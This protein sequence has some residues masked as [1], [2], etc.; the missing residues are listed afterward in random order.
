MAKRL[1]IKKVMNG[2]VVSSGSY[3]ESIYPNLEEVID[4]VRRYFTMEERPKDYIKR[5][6]PG[7]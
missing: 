6:Y 5:R 3:K 4:L 2:F 7:E 1:T